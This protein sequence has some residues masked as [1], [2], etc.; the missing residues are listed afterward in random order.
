MASAPE[1]DDRRR[2]RPGSAPVDHSIRLRMR[3]YSII[4]LVTSLIVIVRG[5]LLGWVGLIPVASCLAIGLTVGLVASRT[6]AMRWDEESGTVVGRIDLIGGVVLLGYILISL[7]RSRLV[8]IW[9]PGTVASVAGLAVVAGVMG[10]QV[11]GTGHGIGR[12]LEVVGLRPSPG[13]SD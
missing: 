10:G 1:R 13:A 5:V 8:G 7:F 2:L 11:I 4:F 9:L 6:Y 12:I 3:I